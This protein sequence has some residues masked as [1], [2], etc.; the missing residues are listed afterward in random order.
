MAAQTR[1]TVLGA[2]VAGLT[3]AVEL[4]E[5]GANVT[6]LERGSRVGEHACSWSAGGMLAPWCERESAEEAVIE[7]GGVALNWWPSHVDGVVRQGTLVVAPARDNAELARFA[8]RTSR[9]EALDGEGVAALEPDLAG[10]F[11]SGLFFPD[12]AHLD[13]R[14]ALAGLES[15]LA[16]LGGHIRFGVEAEADSAEGDAVVDCR[17]FAARAEFPDLRGVR[18][19]M[20]VVRTRE[21]AFQRP[22]RLLHPRIPFYVVP[23][24]DGLFMLGA[25]MIESAER[26]GPVVRSVVD[27]LNAAYALH[28]AFGEAEIVETRADVRPAFP[29]NLPRVDTRGR[30]TYVN[31]LYR[32][33]F[34]LSPA[35]ARAAADA[36]LGP[37]EMSHEADRE[38][39]RA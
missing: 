18:G 26:R 27:L 11:R 30:V 37:K 22:V 39:R 1:V 2:G 7:G 29:D 31:G 8:R 25:T 9:F 6:V 13:P 15:R 23:R 38:R 19:E 16:A 28:P 32:H 24:A 10:R 14:A 34:L 12:E 36:V 33:G 5:R 17:G 21:I 20:L 4:A 35:C 3:T